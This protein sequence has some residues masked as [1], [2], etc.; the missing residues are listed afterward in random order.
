MQR[1]PKHLSAHEGHVVLR[2]SALHH[3]TTGEVVHV[4]LAPPVSLHFDGVGLGFVSFGQPT[5]SLWVSSLFQH[6]LYQNGAGE[7]FV[8]MVV[9]D[10][11]AKLVKLLD[12]RARRHRLVTISLDVRPHRAHS[13]RAAVFHLPQ[14]SCTTFVYIK[15]IHTTLQIQSQHGYLGGWLSRGWSRWFFFFASDRGV[16]SRACATSAWQNRH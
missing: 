2:A 11:A 5:S 7:F 16:A 10:G 1:D 3:R 14:N 12:A 9:A 4:D 6:H 13:I 8:R 15:S